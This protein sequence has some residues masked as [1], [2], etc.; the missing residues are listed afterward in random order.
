MQGG[1][2][3]FNNNSEMDIVAHDL[4]SSL[5]YGVAIHEDLNGLVVAEV[6]FDAKKLNRFSLV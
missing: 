4:N 3:V 6:E 5:T 1:V 2:I